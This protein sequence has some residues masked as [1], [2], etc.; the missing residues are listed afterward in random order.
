MAPKNESDGMDEHTK[1]CKVQAC[2]RGTLVRRQLKQLRQN[3]E[4]LVQELGDPA[5]PVH[6]TWTSTLP[7]VS[8]VLPK[9]KSR[10]Q[11]KQSENKNIKKGSDQG[12]AWSSKRDASTETVFPVN[13]GQDCVGET[14]TVGM[15]STELFH[16][17]L[18]AGEMTSTKTDPGTAD[19]LETCSTNQELS[20]HGIPEG[21][22]QLL[23][24]QTENQENQ[25]RA[26]SSK[27]DTGADAWRETPAPRPE[28][29]QDKENLGG[30]L[31]SE[32]TH[33]WTS[34]QCTPRQTIHDDTHITQNGNSWSQTAAH[35]DSIDHGHT[36]DNSSQA[37][38][39]EPPVGL[40][41]LAEDTSVWVLED[42]FT[43]APGVPVYPKDPAELGKMRRHISME[44]LWV[45]Q[46]IISRKNYLR[47]KHNLEQ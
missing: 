44:L 19:K 28:G 10:M 9:G 37:G 38:P 40:A 14:K 12:A 39:T 22:K 24:P 2:V 8:T 18:Q 26:I 36:S 11:V 29:V 16:S 33:G 4:V 21:N 27:T 6:V 13:T 41:S 30:H 20:Q 17:M 3:Y 32:G 23:P 31:D 1:I 43:G 45:Q 15:E 47:M 5:F 25:T 34:E 46:A 35:W 42:S 7:C